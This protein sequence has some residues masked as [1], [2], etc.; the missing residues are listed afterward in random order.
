[1]TPEGPTK[2]QLLAGTLAALVIGALVVTF[3]ILPAE[4]G[5]DPT[6][7]GNA[8]GL[9]KIKSL[10]PTE[11]QAVTTPSATAP[12]FTATDTTSKPRYTVTWS[13]RATSQTP[14][15]GYL[16]AGEDATLKFT[17]AEANVQLVT[18]RVDWTDANETAAGA[19]TDPDIFEIQITAPDGRQSATVLGQNA[20]PGGAGNVTTTL[21]WRNL[22]PALEFEAA[23]EY[24]A[25]QETAKRAPDDTS[26]TGEW[27]VRVKL[28][29]AGGTRAQP[30]ASLP[31]PV[32]TTSAPDD[33]GNKWNLTVTTSTYRPAIAQKATEPRTDETTLSIEPGKGLEFKLHMS[34][35]QPLDYAWNAPA[36]LYFDFHGE[37]DGAATGVFT[38]HKKGTDAKDQGNFTAPFTGKQGWYFENRGSAPV[39]VTLK[40][41]GY[42]VVLGK[43]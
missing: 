20:E 8:T 1:M 15:D 5:V 38:S 42:Y 24:A 31:V 10:Q 18:A 7:F 17:L 22:P 28:V 6:G 2:K 23:D 29:Q 33:S 21:T 35:G 34:E 27:S 32:P 19:K 4:Y 26:A 9:T 41:S 30:P 25:Q 39:T 43:K 3:G 37:P 16:G 36:Q 14:K 11:S 40:T 12:G 13:T